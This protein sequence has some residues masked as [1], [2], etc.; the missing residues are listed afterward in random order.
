MTIPPA[1]D[2]A[3][4]LVFTLTV[5]GETTSEIEGTLR[6]PWPE[7]VSLDDLIVVAA[8][9]YCQQLHAWRRTRWELA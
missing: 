1:A 8:Q 4:R 6:L 7:N 2:R 3:V 5:E 9:R